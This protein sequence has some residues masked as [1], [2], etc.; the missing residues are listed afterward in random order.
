MSKGVIARFLLLLIAALGT[1][2]STADDNSYFPCR[3]CHGNDGWGSPAIHAPAIAGL[4]ENYLL[5]QLTHYRDGIRGSHQ[6]DTY[7]RQMALMAQNLDDEGIQRLSTFISAMPPPPQTDKTT[8]NEPIALYQPCAVCHGSRG[9]GNKALNSPRIS[10]LDV[11]YLS[12][13][14][15]NFRS[16]V[17]GTD[18]IGQQMRAAA[19]TLTDEEIEQLAQLISSM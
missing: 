9:E 5:R 15:R 11:L 4:S 7:G 2:Y 19:S 18:A 14:L 13:Q 16:G 1:H 17:R 10:G 8:S 3:S 12:T 6:D